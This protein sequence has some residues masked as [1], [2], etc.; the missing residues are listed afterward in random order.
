MI[1]TMNEKASAEGADS[2]PDSSYIDFELSPEK[3]PQTT[4]VIVHDSKMKYV[5]K[6]S[7]FA[8]RGVIKHR[9]S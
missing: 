4:K 8:R 1:P 2:V 7:Q 5:L 3:S 9:S 6:K